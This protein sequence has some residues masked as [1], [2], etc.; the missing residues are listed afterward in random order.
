[1]RSVFF[2]SSII[3]GKYCIWNTA[4][5]AMACSC[6]I[7]FFVLQLLIPDGVGFV[8]AGIGHPGKEGSRDGSSWGSFSMNLFTC[9]ASKV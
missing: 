4:G 5:G 3:T 6:I 8:M 9:N 7:P 2:L 1:M